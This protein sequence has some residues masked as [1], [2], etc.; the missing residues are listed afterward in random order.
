M[1]EQERIRAEEAAERACRD[2]EERE[3]TWRDLMA[4]AHERLI[5][6]HRIARLTANVDAWD[7]A[8]RIR[9]YCDAAEATYHHNAD[10]R[11]WIAWARAHAQRLD[12]LAHAPAFAEPPEAT[13]EALQ[14]HLPDGWSAHGPPPPRPDWMFR[15][16]RF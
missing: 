9:A 4:T 8:L 12:P 15:S 7:Q 11:E 5:E 2:A 13:P 10:A 1:R 16:D 3:R 14:P 6:D